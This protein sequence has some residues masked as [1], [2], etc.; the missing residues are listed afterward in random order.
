M[1]TKT[2]KVSELP[3][4]SADAL[5]GITDTGAAAK[6]AITDFIRYRGITNDLNEATAQGVWRVAT[7][8]LNYP[9]GVIPNSSDYVLTLGAGYGSQ[10][11]ITLSSGGLY[12]RSMLNGSF[13]A[14]VKFTYTP[15]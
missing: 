9:A 4:A 14:W 5:I 7:G 1:S 2:K 12:K 8:C 3:K 13:G 15:V 6:V 11:I 10:T